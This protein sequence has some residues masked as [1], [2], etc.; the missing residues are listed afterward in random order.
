MILL[1]ADDKQV[2]AKAHFQRAEAAERGGDLPLAI[3]EYRA[4]Y[5][6]VPHAA[7][8]YNIARDEEKLDDALAAAGDYQRY[9]EESVELEDADSVRKKIYVLRGKAGTRLANQAL[10]AKGG[11]A[12]LAAVKSMVI[13][14]T[15]KMSSP[16]RPDR[17]GRIVR[18][19][20]GTT[21]MR[22]EMYDADDKLSDVQV[23]TPE[24][25]WVERGG[26]VLW[27]N[28]DAELDVQAT[29][30][31]DKDLVLLRSREEGSVVQGM[32]TVQAGERSFDVLSISR[33]DGSWK[34]VLYLDPHSHL[35]EQVEAESLSGKVHAEVGDLHEVHGIHF[36][37]YSTS[38]SGNVTLEVHTQGITLDQDLD[39][40]LF[41]RPVQ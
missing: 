2:Q 33:A 23:V 35:L 10:A 34:T 41:E 12:R 17:T 3:R 16:G 11:A 26:H 19:I 8:L 38:R 30:W 32:G 40:T 25:A 21:R 36:P 7:V 20:Q 5:A 1:F 29:L 15:Y 18:Y 31:R 39:P 27:G 28:K 9:L 14:A 4:A 6:L 24:T 13:H 22:V 37:F